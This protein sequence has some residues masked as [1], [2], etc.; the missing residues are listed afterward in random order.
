MSAVKH[1][2]T[3]LDRYWQIFIILFAAGFTFML[4]L[5]DPRN[6]GSK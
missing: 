5:F 6:W 3:W 2:Q 4:A 1:Q